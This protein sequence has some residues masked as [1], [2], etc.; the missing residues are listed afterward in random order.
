MI[1]CNQIE[2]LGFVFSLNGPV[3]SWLDSGQVWCQT[4]VKE[5]K[6]WQEALLR[7]M[8]ALPMALDRII[9]RV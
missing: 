9:K 1:T 3:E 2:K 8:R 4:I 7:V 5:R 6:K